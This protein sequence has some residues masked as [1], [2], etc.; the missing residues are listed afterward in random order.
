VI[1]L[2]EAAQAVLERK[3]GLALRADGYLETARTELH[4]GFSRWL[5]DDGE[6]YTARAHFSDSFIV[7][8]EGG[9]SHYA[10]QRCSLPATPGWSAQGQDIRYVAFITDPASVRLPAIERL[11]ELYGFTAAQARAACELAMGGSYA[12]VAARL[13]ISEHTLRSHV[14]AI[15][16]KARV[17]RQADLVRSIL[18]LGQVAV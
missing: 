15:Y 7:P 10:V 6:Q 13:N 12:E 14:K 2:N 3:D 11:C 1:H 16:P 9:T 4:H 18:S 5:A 8:R 17:N